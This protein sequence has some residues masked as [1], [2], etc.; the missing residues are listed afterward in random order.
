MGF[1]EIT[2]MHW[3]KTHGMNGREQPVVCSKKEHLSNDKF[4]VFN[5]MSTEGSEQEVRNKPNHMAWGMRAQKDGR[6]SSRRDLA[7]R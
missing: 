6:N 4:Q 2:G 3:Q 1:I 5:Q 7:A